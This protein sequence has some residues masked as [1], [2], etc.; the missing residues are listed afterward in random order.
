[1]SQFCGCLGSTKPEPRTQI[2]AYPDAGFMP[3]SETQMAMHMHMQ[4][5]PPQYDSVDNGYSPVVPLPRYTPRP[6]SIHEKTLENNMQR[7]QHRAD[8]K[9]RQDFASEDEEDTAALNFQSTGSSSATVTA[10]TAPT[11]IMDDASSAYSF[12]SSF[13]HTSTETRDTPPPPYSSCGSSF[14]ARSRASSVRS[15]R[16]SES[17]FNYSL[18]TG[19]NTSEGVP[20]APAAAMIAPPPIAHVQMS[21]NH[22]HHYQSASI[23]HPRQSTSRSN[24]PNQR[25][26]SWESR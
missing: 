10:I 5:Q 14:Y 21:R 22:Q 15:H 7:P 23:S 6:M 1:M 2:P 18:N 3:R 19:N 9:N 4:H 24:T 25:R 13:G 26:L 20:A 8:E 17:L 11:T 12:P 16:R